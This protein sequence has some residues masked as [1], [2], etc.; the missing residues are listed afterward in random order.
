[1]A[2]WRWILLWKHYKEG[3]FGPKSLIKHALFALS[4]VPCILSIGIL[5]CLSPLRAYDLYS[6]TKEGKIPN[7]YATA[8]RFATDITVLD[9]SGLRYLF[10][11]V[12]KDVLSFCVT[13]PIAL[14]NPF[15]WHL[16][17]KIAYR[18]VFQRSEYKNTYYFYLRVAALETLFWSLILLLF[19][20][21][22]LSIVQIPVV[23]IVAYRLWTNEDQFLEGRRQRRNGLTW[24]N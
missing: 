14:V 3:S 1:M 6:L 8:G 21:S 15:N 12:I 11:S 2:F 19:V 5:V 24:V 18:M 7:M 9:G 4:E 20:C 17:V 13:L 23:F 10:W 16:L 22:L